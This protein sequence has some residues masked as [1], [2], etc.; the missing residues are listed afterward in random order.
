MSQI[1]TVVGMD[2]AGNLL[3]VRALG[4]LDEYQRGG[5][6]YGYRY[7]WGVNHY[8]FTENKE[9][10]MEAYGLTTAE[11]DQWNQLF[12]MRFDWGKD[13][14]YEDDAV[15]SYRTLTQ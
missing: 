1:A 5:R 9:A 7:D 8:A 10:T 2:H 6:M 13:A 14:W 11:W 15:K 3:Q 12:V 4:P